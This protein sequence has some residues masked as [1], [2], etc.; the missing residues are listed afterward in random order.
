VI[1]WP[2]FKVTGNELPDDIVK[3]VPLSVAELIVTAAV[4]VEVKVTDRVDVEPVAT[5]PNAT[6]LALTLS[7]GVELLLP[8][9]APLTGTRVI[10][11]AVE[12]VATRAKQAASA[13]NSL[14]HQP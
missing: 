7:C 4:P 2:G 6:L 13:I 11:W 5:L 10:C 9:P 14:V 8:D 12:F 3:P 1:A